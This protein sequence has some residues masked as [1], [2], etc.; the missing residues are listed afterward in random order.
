MKKKEEMTARLT[1][2][3]FVRL[4]SSWGSLREF[5]GMDFVAL[6]VSGAEAPGVDSEFPDSYQIR[7]INTFIPFIVSSYPGTQFW[8]GEKLARTHAK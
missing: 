3:E 1:K 4:F 7:V 2:K 5:S 6:A 8:W